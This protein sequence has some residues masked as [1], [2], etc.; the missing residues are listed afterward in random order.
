MIITADT[1]IHPSL[2]NITYKGEILSSVV[3]IDTEKKELTEY[4]RV[5]NKLTGEII[6]RSIDLDYLHVYII[7]PVFKIE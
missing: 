2:L 1:L 5:N 3:S 7:K 6:T 4:E